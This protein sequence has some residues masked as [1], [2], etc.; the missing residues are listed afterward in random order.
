ML[1]GVE[2]FEPPTFGFGDRR[3]TN[4]SYTPNATYFKYKIKLYLACEIRILF[5]E[6]HS[7]MRGGTRI[8]PT[9]LSYTSLTIALSK[10]GR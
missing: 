8:I 5:W 7:H 6:I 3:S 10:L 4:S 2:G 1:A 9:K